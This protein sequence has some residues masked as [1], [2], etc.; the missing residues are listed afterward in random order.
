MGRYGRNDVFIQVG[1]SLSIAVSTLA[2]AATALA[3]SWTPLV[4]LNASGGGATTNEHGIAADGS[5]LHVLLTGSGMLRYRRSTDN[6]GTWNAS[7]TLA[8]PGGTTSIPNVTRAGSVLNALWADTRNGKN[9][10]YLRRSPDGGATWEP[11]QQLTNG[12]TVGRLASE[13]WGSNVHLVYGDSTG[14]IF[15]RRSTDGG[16][17]WGS[18]VRVTN[19]AIN[20]G[21]PSVAVFQNY[22][23]VTWEDDDGNDF[24]RV[25]Y[26]RSPDN[27]ATF[28]AD[29]IVTGTT[30]GFR[31]AIATAPETGVVYLATTERSDAANA[32]TA[33]IFVRRSTDGGVTFAPP[34]RIT[35]ANG[36]SEHVSISAAGE[37]VYMAWEDGINGSGACCWSAYYAGSIDGGTTWS[38]PEQV[39]GT[40]AGWLGFN[41]A[42][43]PLYAHVLV[44]SS[45]TAPDVYYARR[46]TGAGGSGTGGAPSSGGAAGATNSGGAQSGGAAGATSTGGAS[47]GGA[48]S[49]GGMKSSA[50][51]ANGNGGMM[52]STGGVT[53]SGATSPLMGGTTGEGGG[54]AMAAGGANDGSGGAASLVGSDAGAETIGSARTG[55][56]RARPVSNQN[57]A[58]CDCSFDSSSTGADHPVVGLGILLFSYLRRRRPP[59]HFG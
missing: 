2:H 15:Y 43:T 9:D 48:P 26:V 20:D 30:W 19:S 40:G 50:G 51:A 14:E 22:V 42:A 46:S 8:S 24:Y 27:G 18:D 7:V 5:T 25:H 47:R 41:V 1:A 4:Q 33:E 16:K 31:P 53:G 56:P 35:N 59:E 12:K 28:G 44:T 52:R 58:G 23:Y 32:D 29:A 17:T 3:G 57:N 55:G 11:E 36:S 21:R 6:G 37:S 34:K 39:P 54:A 13:A 38:T 49:G 45:W 10:I